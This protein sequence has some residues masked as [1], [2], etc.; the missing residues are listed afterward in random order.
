MDMLPDGSRAYVLHQRLGTVS[1][2][3]TRSNELVATIP[4]SGTPFARGR[5]V[6]P[7]LPETPTIQ[8]L[9]D[10]VRSL[11][12]ISNRETASLEQILS[13]ARTQLLRS[14][15]VAAAALMQAFVKQVEARRGKGITNDQ[16]TLLIEWANQ[17]LVK[18]V[19]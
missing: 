15:T 3:N 17:I 18:L 16:A 2:V 5:F 14:N 12:F 9:I 7:G 10:A 8:E 13:E 4:V 11:N 19:G 6:V 1:A